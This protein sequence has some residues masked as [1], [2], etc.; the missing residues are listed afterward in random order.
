M[1]G[2]A[3]LRWVYGSH[4][5]RLSLH[6]LIKRGIFSRLLGWSKNRATSRRD[7]APFIEQYGINIEEALESPDSF[8]SFNEFF[9]RKLKAGARPLCAEGCVAL[10]AD[11]RHQAWQDASQMEGVFVK[12]QR[13]DLAALLGSE[14]LAQRYAKGSIVLSRL[15]PVDYHR[16]HFP[17]AGVPAAPRRIAGALASVS[18]YCLRTQLSWLWNNKRDLTVLSTEAA[19]DVLLLPIGATGVGAIHHTYEPNVAV[20]RGAEQ[21]YFAF[22]GS[23]VM[24]FYLPGRVAIAQDLLENTQRGYETFARQGDVLGE[25]R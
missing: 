10:P 20:D 5:G 21:G 3:A 24:S 16:F 6:V 7:I 22:G 9:Y 8:G 19:G 1:L 14:E 25:L 18:P 11:A 13:F 23:T 12:G 4:L 2:E 17:L 15:C